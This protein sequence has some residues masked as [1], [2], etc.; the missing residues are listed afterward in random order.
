MKNEITIFFAPEKE[1]ELSML[2]FFFS[3]S[4]W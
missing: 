3:L 4:I 2:A 1:M